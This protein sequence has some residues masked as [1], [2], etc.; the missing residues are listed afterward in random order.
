MTIMRDK[1]EALI[2]GTDL[3]VLTDL[4]FCGLGAD[5]NRSAISLPRANMLNGSVH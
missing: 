2:S 4:A 5:R 3:T 1:G